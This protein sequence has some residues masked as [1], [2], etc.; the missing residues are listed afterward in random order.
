MAQENE[1]LIH[2]GQ[3]DTPRKLELAAQEGALNIK[4]YLPN[5]CLLNQLTIQHQKPLAQSTPSQHSARWH[6]R[7]QERNAH[8]SAPQPTAP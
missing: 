7:A 8:S 1:V 3:Q 4:H 5:H 2:T 6:H